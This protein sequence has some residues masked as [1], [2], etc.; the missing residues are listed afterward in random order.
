MAG[1]RKRYGADFKAKVALEALRGELTTA[2]LASKCDMHQ[3]MVSDWKQQAT[4]GL[5]SLFAGK[6]M[7]GEAACRGRAGKVARHN[8]PGGGGTGFFGESL[9]SMSAGRRREMIEPGHPT[10]SVVRRCELVC[11]SRSTFYRTPTPPTA[12]ELTL[13]RRIDEQFVESPYF[14]ARRM[15]PHLRRL[16]FEVG[17]KRV[18]RLMATMGLTPIYQRPRTSIPC[19]VHRIYLHLLDDLVIDRVNQVWCTRHHVYSDAPRSLVS[20]CD[21]GLGYPQGSGLASVEHHGCRFLYQ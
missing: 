16:G 9:R 12:L 5:A 15:V 8:R 11:L 19:P 18:Q 10:L 13:M 20:G 1:K 17:R 6:A 3:T 2:Q 21:H 14:G 7:V 4:E